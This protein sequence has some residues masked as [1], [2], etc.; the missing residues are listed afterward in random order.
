MLAETLPGIRPE[1]ARFLAERARI[2]RAS[3]EETLWRQGE[4]VP[5]TL[6]MDGYGGFRRN[7][8]DGQQVTVGI[9]VPG[10]IFGI[11]SVSSTIATVDMFAMTECV[12]ASWQGPELRSLA[13]SDP[14]LALELLDRMSLFLNILTAKLDGFL[15]QGSR[16]RVIRILS[17]YRPLFFSDPPVLS[18]AHLPGLVG[19]S[20]EMTGRVIRQLEREG[21]IARV[22][23]TGLR[24]PDPQRLDAPSDLPSSR[25]LY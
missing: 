10:E 21:T 20:R 24:L 7:T 13:A 11:T 5:L 22:G 14:D 15:H 25:G 2:Y 6:I 17:R 8:A 23:R 19:T 12:V 18:R 1:L 16:R 4:E 9:A 3:S